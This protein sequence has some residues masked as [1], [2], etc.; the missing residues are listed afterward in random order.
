MNRSPKKVP[1]RFG[2][3]ALVRDLQSDYGQG[4]WYSRPVDPA[5]IA[6][7]LSG[8]LAIHALRGG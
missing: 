7:L 4:Y 8:T 3:C 2:F 6:E 5:T 1:S